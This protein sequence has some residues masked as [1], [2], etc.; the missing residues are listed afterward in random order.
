VASPTPLLPPVIR[1]FLSASLPIV[2]TPYEQR[3]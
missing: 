3:L 2:V 1:I